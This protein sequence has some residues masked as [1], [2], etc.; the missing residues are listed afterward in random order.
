MGQA[1]R[2]RDSTH[3]S[4]PVVRFQPR[5][6]LV[7]GRVAGD[8]SGSSV[9]LPSQHQQLQVCGRVRRG[10]TNTCKLS[11]KNLIAGCIFTGAQRKM[12]VVTKEKPQRAG[13]SLNAMPKSG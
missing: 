13:Q 12:E 3:F 11:A 8:P 6:G 2:C 1:T 10:D 4:V 7:S 5:L 9:F